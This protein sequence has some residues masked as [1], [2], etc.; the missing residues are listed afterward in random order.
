[1]LLALLVALGVAPLAA[2]PS[3]REPRA[4]LD[5]RDARALANSFRQARADAPAWRRERDFAALL[6]ALESL[7]SHGLMPA[8]YQLATLRRLR[9]NHQARDRIATEA[10]FA[11]AVD[12]LRGKVDPRRVEPDWTA[13]AREADLP[14]LLASALA[15]GEPAAAL[16]SLAPTHP[17]YRM[18]RAALAR[19]LADPASSLP[20]SG[21]LPASHPLHEEPF[22]TQLFRD[23][24]ASAASLTS[25]RAPRD[26]ANLDTAARIASL[27]ASLERWRW[28]PDDLGRRHVRVDIPAYRVTAYDGNRI[29]QRHRAIVGDADTRTPV[30]S[31]RI[32]YIVFNPWWETPR[33]IA[34]RDELPVFR[35][36]PSAARVLG[37]QVLDAGGRRIDPDTI[38]WHEV[39][40]AAFPYRLRQ[41]PG[42]FNALGRAKIMFPNRHDVY[43]HD[44][45]APELFLDTE[46][47]YSS[48]CV[49]TDGIATL[50]AWLLAETPQWSG[51]RVTDAMDGGRTIRADLARPVPVHLLYFT[52]EPD[53]ARIDGEIRYLDDIYGRDPRLI[54][55]LDRTPN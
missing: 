27:R 37:F 47:T 19:L 8:D 16:L 7:R 17:E 45:A 32:R 50:S 29:V 14:R 5:S 54:D 55:L 9:S 33:S 40:A 38:D 20:S 25:S 2:A 13:P 44:T 12:L 36:Y 53:P 35:R 24:R 41:A 1:M 23:A 22:L 10:W 6:Q 4:A 11:A 42:P 51:R 52:A 15:N 28:L 34:V 26:E 49:R 39:S 43:L 21:P 46:R 3:M 31:D 18:L 30:F 48:G